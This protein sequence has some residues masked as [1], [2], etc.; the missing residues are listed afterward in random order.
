MLFKP[1]DSICWSVLELTYD[2]IFTSEEVLICVKLIV[3]LFKPI[4]S[5]CWSV[6]K[7]T[8]DFIFT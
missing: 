8:Y 4:N 5:I 2:F 6:L 3:M 1:I 7:L